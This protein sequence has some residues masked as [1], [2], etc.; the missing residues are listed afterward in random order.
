MKKFIAAF[1]SLN[2][3]ESTLDYAIFLAKN[4]Q[5]HLVGVFLEDAA[6]H[7]YSIADVSRYEGADFDKHVAEAEEHDKE[8][9]TKSKHQF[10]AACQQSS[11]NYAIHRDKN[12]AI[13]DL[14]HESIY[15]DLLIINAGETL[16]RY[17]EAAPSRFIRDLLTEVQCPVVLTPPK[18]KPIDKVVML[19]DGEPSSVYAVRNFGY[20]FEFATRLETE[21]IT[22]KAP[23][24]SMHVP[25]NK[26]VKEFIKRHFPKA[27]YVLLK[28]LAEDEIIKYLH[29]EKK[30]PLIVLG[31]YKRNKLSRLF[32]PSMADYLLEHLK[33]PLF[34][35][36]NR[37]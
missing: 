24:E 29:R 20:L 32:R 1:D 26:L 37:S 15:A 11:L 25:D 2:F 8:E 30:D 17:E 21:V 33:M 28:G 19:Y 27:E 35:A 9:R 36:H 10:E 5:A 3:S 18:Y 14:L 22:V 23:E 4:S 13:D 16:N 12:I 7:S 6:R 34:I 31:A